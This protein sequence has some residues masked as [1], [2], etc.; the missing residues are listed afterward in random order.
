MQTYIPQAMTTA[1]G[2]RVP[3]LIH[4]ANLAAKFYVAMGISEQAYSEIAEYNPL[5]AQYLV[6]HAHYRRVLM[7]VNLRELYHLF[8]L[9]TSDM[10]HFSIREPMLEAMKQVVRIHPML[11]QGLKLRDYPKWWSDFLPHQ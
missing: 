9:R 11:F 4:D 6:T 8:K 1:H 10:A 3:Q 2:F 5:A 7:T